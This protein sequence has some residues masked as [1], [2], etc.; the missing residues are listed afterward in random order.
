MVK[1][2]N[3]AGLEPAAEMFLGSSPSKGTKKNG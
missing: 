3:T 1:L 2:V